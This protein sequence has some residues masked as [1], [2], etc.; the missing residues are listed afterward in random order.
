MART[1]QS[2][3]YPR[4]AF[5]VDEALATAIAARVKEKKLPSPSAYLR[6]LV[7]SDLKVKPDNDRI[8]RLENVMSANHVQ[9]AAILRSIA[10]TQRATYGLLDVAVKAILAYI[11]DEG[12]PDMRKAVQT[13]GEQRYNVVH[14]DARKAGLE[15]LDMLAKEFDRHRQ[16]ANNENVNDLLE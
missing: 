8:A 13:R 1:Q 10:I 7:E 15:M 6:A 9:V 12:G 14:K 16:T 3:P 2:K 5:R 11:P 4:V